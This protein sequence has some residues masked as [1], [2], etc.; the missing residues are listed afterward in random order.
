MKTLKI[1]YCLLLLLAACFSGCKSDEPIASGAKPEIKIILDKFTPD[2]NTADNIPLVCVI[3]SEVG[4]KSVDIWIMKG[5]EQVP[6][7]TVKE[8]WDP[9]QYSAK[10]MP[11]W[12]EDMSEFIISATDRAGQTTKTS[13]PIS[14]IGYKAP[15]TIV[16]ELEK[17]VVD[18]TTGNMDSPTTRFSVTGASKLTA[19]EVNLFKASGTQVIALTPSL[20]PSFTY[21]FEQDILYSEGDVALQ[22]KATDAYGKIKIETLPITYVSVPSPSFTP[23]GTTPTTIVAKSGTNA[24]LTYNVASGA[25]LS[26]IRIYK[27]IKGIE[28]ELTELS[29]YY[30]G[31]NNVSFTAKLPDFEG[32]WNAIKLVAA[33]RLGRSTTLVVP[34]IIDLRYKADILI[35]SQYYSILQLPKEEFPDL[36]Y[37]N[38]DEEIHCF[39]SVNDMKTYSLSDSYHNIP[40]IDFIFFLWNNM[41]FNATRIYGASKARPNEVW[42]HDPANNI[43]YMS[44]WPG[45]N[46]TQIK[47]F[48]PTSWPFDF[49]NVTAADLKDANVQTYIGQGQ[50]TEDFAFYNVGDAGLF[51]TAPT[52]TAPSK[53][54]MFRIEALKVLTINAHPN[55]RGYY[56]VTFK[57]LE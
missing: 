26:A 23:T 21:N 53:T 5:G 7:K 32:N 18:E 6:F 4:L 54:G 33:D 55:N 14:A 20:T 22:V 8:F 24:T 11:V 38:T 27:V 28:T 36:Q 57:V 15:P 56:I 45:L 40:N 50:I 46:A 31:E 10:E 3:S 30:T 44:T 25:G 37:S 47:R 48:H 17:I 35:G 2:M 49:D 43:P 39:F 19:I 42:S 34:T 51:R 9:H 52:S 12:E 29:N 13:M 1:H 16:F 41:D